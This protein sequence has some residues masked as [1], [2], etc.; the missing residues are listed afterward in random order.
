MRRILVITFVSLFCATAAGAD[1]GLEPWSANAHPTDVEKSHV[2]EITTGPHEYTIAQGGTMDG[3][4]CRSPMGCGMSREGA[5]IQT[6]ESNRS[7]RMENVG[8]TD[9]VNPWLSNGR[10]NFRSVDEIVSSAVTP[11]MTDAEKAFALW[12]QEIR[13]R[14]HSPGDNSEL[15]DPVKVFN[16]YG[17]NT[18][19]N[20]SICLGTLWHKAGLKTAPAR[21]LGH[22]ISQAFYDD[23]WH[24]YDGDLHCVYLLRDNE[25]VAGE[26]DIVRDHDLIKRTHSQGILLRDNVWTDHGAAALYFYEGEVTGERF[27]KAD[28]TM[29]MVLRPGE[30]IVWRWGQTTPLKYHGMLRVTPT[31]KNVIC[32]GVWEYRPDFSAR[33]WRKGATTI[34]NVTSGADGLA[35]EEGKTGTI[36]W[37][38]QSPYV[39]VGGRLEVEGAQAK[40]SLSRDGKTWQAVGDSL[41]KLFPIVGPA[42][43]EYRLRCQLEG[44]ARLQRL[45]VVNDVQMAP[46]ALPELAVG[47]NTFTYT[48]E[49]TAARRV[50]IT[51]KWVERS[52][53]RP[54]AAPPTPVFPPD[55]GESNGTDVV[56]RW[57][58]PLDSDGDAIAD[59]HFE[60]SSRGDMKWPL[61][62]SFY[63]LISRTADVTKEKNEHTGKDKVAVK[64]QYTLPQPGLL[65]PDRAYYWRVRAQDDRGVW[66]PWSKTWSFT[67]RGPSHPLQVTVDCDQLRAVGTLRW[68]PNPI[69]RQPV[70]YRVYGSDEKGFTIGDKKY[71]GSVGAS[72]ELSLWFPANFVA[73][74][75]A[76]E[77]AVIGRD[78]SLPAANKTYYRVVAVDEQGKRSGPSDYATAPRPVIYSRPVVAA[79]VG[80]EY[81]YQVLAN[82]SLGD[83]RSRMVDG[84]QVKSFWDVERLTFSLERGPKWLEIDEAT[85]VLSGTPDAAGKVEVVVNAAAERQVRKLDE[86]TLKW[87]REKVLSETTERVGSDSQKF[88]I[89]V[90]QANVD[91]AAQKKAEGLKIFM[92]WDMEGV[93][94]LFT[95][96]QAWYWEEGV[97]KE[98]AD[99]ARELLIADIN[100]ATRAA[101]EAGVDELIICDTH[102]GG[103][104]IRLDKMLSDPRV[105]YLERSV[106][107]QNGKRRWM[108][109]LDETVDGLML[110]AHHAKAGT[111]GAFLPHAQTLAWAD[112][113][114]N[115]QSVGEIGIETCYAGHWNVPLILVQGDE[116][117]CRETQQQFPG[118]VTAAVKRAES[119]DRCSGLDAEAA[120]RLTARKVTEAIQQLHAASFKPFKPALPM[121]VTIRMTTPDKARA[122]AQRPGV[123]KIDQYTVEARV[124]RQCDVLKWI[125]GTGLDMPK[126]AI[127]RSE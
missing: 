65:A 28:T 24:F 113:R 49:C 30:A 110:M 25:T 122:A 56:F 109:G 64:A 95:R 119:H 19:G 50:R 48:D 102:H 85:G 37:T 16:T 62:M 39:F 96:E 9:C 10:N 88:A 72:K 101:L 68:E 57:T 75:A 12:F 81:R 36:V 94:G 6:W 86:P 22:C 78:V 83:L 18:C 5:F 117:A 97:S 8:E 123:Q 14:H 63:K 84:R 35:A 70:K 115:G 67:P 92:H 34:E 43:Y 42:C 38:M 61:S 100:S 21:A 114:I 121:T 11:G 106:G 7:V 120:R 108:P 53:S 54:P 82:R 107:V 93:S 40:F 104:N 29:N 52:A 105:T 76:T 31:Y 98:T 111:E 91:T 112:V 45:A 79:K 58:P 15:G 27:G 44:G 26:Q 23:G 116:A 77:M 124:T 60:L 71:Q 41:D 17:Y 2:E 118:A 4:N 33:S 55:A 103:G 80:A 46:M 13:Y 125:I 47:E 74:T 127:D 89:D 73:E 66:G 126:P 90:Q 51:H 32:N 59:Y 87:G 20:D 69:G 99:E 3:R 1:E